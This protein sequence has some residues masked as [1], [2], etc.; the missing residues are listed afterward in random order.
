MAKLNSDWIKFF[1]EQV[2]HIVEEIGKLLFDV[3]NLPAACIYCGDL[4]IAIETS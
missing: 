2:D 3:V 1:T 4:N